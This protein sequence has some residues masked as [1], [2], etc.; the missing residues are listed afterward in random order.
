MVAEKSVVSQALWVPF[1]ALDPSP[2]IWLC[3]PWLLVSTLFLLLDYSVPGCAP[4]VSYSSI[5]VQL[6][7]SHPTLQTLNLIQSLSLPKQ[8]LSFLF[9]V[10]H[11][12]WVSHPHLFPVSLLANPS[13]LNSLP[14]LTHSQLPPVFLQVVPVPVF[15][16]FYTLNP[17]LIILN[18]V[19]SLSPSNSNQSHYSLKSDVFSLI[20]FTS[21]ITR[22]LVPIYYLPSPLVQILFHLQ[23]IQK[24]PPPLH[25]LGAS[26]RKRRVKSPRMTGPL[27]F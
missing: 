19:G 6:I 4:Q 7:T 3:P 21:L 20:H 9:W 15:W 18:P 14:S 24:L 25:C 16:P 1:Q 13:P 8:T 22:H 27:C 12:I 11:P 17:S 5:L 2:Q 23:V 10:S 26:R